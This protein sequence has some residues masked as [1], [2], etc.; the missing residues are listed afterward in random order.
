MNYPE[1]LATA[2]NYLKKSIP[3]MMQHQLPANPVN[4]TLWYNYVANHVPALNNA[5][6]NIVGN[7]GT[8]SIEQAQDLYF[9]Y[10]ISEHLEDHQKTLEGI[11]ELASE[12]V[13]HLSRSMN[14]GEVFSNTLTENIDMLREAKS[15]E[16]VG[17]LIENV[18]ATSE[19]IRTANQTFISNMQTANNEISS[20]RTQL[21]QAEKSAFID[22]LTQ[23]YNRHAFDRQLDQLLQTDSVAENVYLILVDLDHFKS[24]NDDY[25]HVIGDRVLQR[26]GE[27]IQDHSPDN[28]IGARY[29]GEEF[30]IIISNS[31]TEYA[32]DVAESLRL[33]LQQL[34]VK[35]KNSDKVLNNI[36]ASFGIARYQIG[37]GA[38]N[39]IDRADKALYSAKDGGR[40]QVAIYHPDMMNAKA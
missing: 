1:N 25:G 35:I 33:K 5:V 3:H 17:P 9:Q 15:I 11:T 26:M 37:E 38:E 31:T 39:L 20:L 40:N 18:I 22:Q 23:L 8:L 16:E 29:G 21:Q 2:A 19:T 36:T 6:E 28:A 24:F 14:G 32:H 27:L 13:Q 12:L 10:I 30:A 34:R 4:Y 7:N